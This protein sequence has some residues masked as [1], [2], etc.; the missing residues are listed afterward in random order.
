MAEELA[1][2][3]ITPP[4]ELTE[5]DK[6][7]IFKHFFCRLAE[8]RNTCEL[9]ASLESSMGMSSD[10]NLRRLLNKELNVWAQ[11]LLEKAWIVCYDHEKEKCPALDEYADTSTRTLPSLPPQQDL[12]KVLNTI[13]FLMI[14][15]SKS[16]SA[17]TRA[18]MSTF[19]PLD[20]QAIVTT[21]KNPER[22]IEQAQKQTD[23]AKD[24]HAQR[25][26]TMRAIGVGLGAVAGGVLVGVTGGLAAPLVGA[27][28]ATVLGWLGVGGSI[29]GL[30]ASGLA[31]SSVV[32]A[33]LFGYYGATSS[34]NM[35]EKH[36]RELRDLAIVPVKKEKHD[37]T[38][39]VRLCVSG[40]LSSPEDVTAPWTVFGGD[41]TFALQWEIEA[42]EE[43]SNALSTL[44]KTQVMHILKAEILR[45]T[46]L[47]TLMSSLAPLA[48]LKIG[49]IIDNPWMNAKALAAKAG[50][51][52]GDLLAKRVFGTRPV[53][54]TGY[55]LGSLVIFEALQHLASL[56]PSETTHLIQDVFLFGTPAPTDP[57]VWAS[58]RRLVAG[59]IVNGYA[60]DDYILAVLSRVSNASW[61]VAGL[62]PVNVKGVENVLCECVTGHIMWRG[63][64]GKCLEVCGAPGIVKSEVEV[65]MKEVA[66]PM[67]KEIE[68]SEEVEQKS[69]E[70]ASNSGGR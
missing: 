15:I 20:E 22:A 16:Y 46:I 39:G 42:L 36:T 14:T 63:M 18:F 53:T 64:I 51:I 8:Y 66:V 40:W 9:Y 29:L 3:K 61:E 60:S 23:E 43:L 1:L 44:L 65:Q 21:L 55:S 69:K 12:A 68:M 4:K 57:D 13:L 47:A 35:V 70:G 37:E 31:S 27:G 49:Q 48:W 25:G 41:D 17:R 24:D 5:R 32:C 33:A 7:T 10:E 38:L 26:K 19:G 45:R 28:V 6:D 11:S 67:E 52:L 59:R 2:E 62:H 50:A 58:I 34:A 30:L 56:P 54:L